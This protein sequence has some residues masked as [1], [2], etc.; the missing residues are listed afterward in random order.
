MK[1]FMLLA[2][3]ATS[4]ATTS[5]VESLQSQAGTNA[6]KVFTNLHKLNVDNCAIRAYICLDLTNKAK[7][8]TSVCETMYTSCRAMMDELYLKNTG[9]AYPYD[10]E[11]K[12]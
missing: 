3:L 4:C 5:S 8:D 12:K 11:V 2:L 10:A 7:A 6:S 9:T 1:T